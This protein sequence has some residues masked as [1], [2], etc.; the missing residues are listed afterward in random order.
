MLICGVDEAGR[1]PLA[2]P[3]VTA[4]VVFDNKTYI[5]GIKDSKKLSSNKREELYEQIIQA[6]IWWD[7]EVIGVEVIDRVNIT[8]ATMI[9]FQQSLE[10]L[11]REDVEVLVDGNYFK[12]PD[13]ENF[14]FPYKT[15]VRGDSLI[16]Q[17][18]AAS[19]LAKVTR[20]RLMQEYHLKYPL[21][22]FARNKG[23]P[24]RQHIESIK[25]FGLCE[26]HR[27][28]FCKKYINQI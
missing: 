18:S 25:Q 12:L 23:Y 5:Q 7:V 11:K 13:M 19:I 2:G 27:K 9:G 15:I 10:K 16:Y 8:K 17:I 14:R 3:V 6:A 4:A 22:N 1:G 28:T 21:Y 24:T 26:I 20:D